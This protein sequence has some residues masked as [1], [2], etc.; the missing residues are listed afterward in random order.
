MTDME[1]A[2]SR[3][4]TKGDIYSLRRDH[5]GRMDGLDQR[6]DKLEYRVGAVEKKLDRV[7]VE[8]VRTQAD[9]REIR[10]TMATKDDVRALLGPIHDLAAKFEAFGRMATIHGQALTEGQGTLK[11]HE[12]RL[13]A[14]E[15]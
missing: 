9:V 12:R 2:D 4:A 8:L 10:A 5:C 3:P 13:R 15:S 6:M 11:D 14:L 7:V 1:A